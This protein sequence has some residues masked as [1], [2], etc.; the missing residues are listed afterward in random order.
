M[1]CARFCDF[2]P[3]NVEFCP[4]TQVNYWWVILILYRLSFRFYKNEFIF[5]FSPQ[6]QDVTLILGLL[7]RHGPPQVLNKSLKFFIILF[8]LAGLEL[9]LSPRTKLLLKPQISSI[10]FLLV[11]FESHSV[12]AQIEAATDLS[13]ICTEILGALPLLLLPSRLFCID[14]QLL[15]QS[16]DSTV[17]YSAW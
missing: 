17:V 2:S 10:C 15:L 9:Q 6:P 7:L 13:G 14:I 4:D 5:A 16:L 12:Q 1:I 3:K 8:N 11:S